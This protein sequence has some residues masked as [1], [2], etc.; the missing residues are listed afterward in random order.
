M[1]TITLSTAIL[2]ILAIAITGC[3]TTE[4]NTQV[5]PGADLSGYETYAILPVPDKI[6]GIDPGVV[7]RVRGIVRDAVEKEMNAKRYLMAPVS[8]ADIVV[9]ITGQVV[10]KV[11]ITQWGYMDVTHHGWVHG[12]PYYGSEISVDQYEEG[13]LIIEV[14]NRPTKEMVWVGWGKT[15]RSER[16]PD[17]DRIQNTVN[18]IL[19][20]FPTSTR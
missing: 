9:N 1:K 13:T 10:P 4:I 5:A 2:V 15:R 3:Q 11:D 14:Y 16:G 18:Q 20:S 17:P 12:Y 19:E 7:L 6:P 8:E